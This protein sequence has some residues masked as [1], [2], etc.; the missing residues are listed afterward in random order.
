MNRKEGCIGKAAKCY[1]RKLDSLCLCQKALVCVWAGCLN[2]IFCAWLLTSFPF[3]GCLPLSCVSQN[4]EHIQFQ[5]KAGEVLF[6]P[7][8]P[9]SIVF[10]KIRPYISQKQHLKSQNLALPVHPLCRRRLSPPL[11]LTLGTSKIS[12]R[13]CET[14]RSGSNR[15]EKEKTKNWKEGNQHDSPQQ[16]LNKT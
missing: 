3:A 7:P 15:K 10:W 1:L 13:I 8:S 9:L 14:S 11:H 4:T 16:N 5:Q 6:K 12:I 2:R